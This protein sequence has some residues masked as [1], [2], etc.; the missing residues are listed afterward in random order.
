MPRCSVLWG[1]APF[2]KVSPPH[3]PLRCF[4]RVQQGFCSS[5]GML[6]A[7]P[8]GI[9]PLPHVSALRLCRCWLAALAA[10]LV[11]FGTSG[12]HAPDR[13]W[14]IEK[15]RPKRC[16]FICCADETGGENIFFCTV[17][18]CVILFGRLLH[19]GMN[20]TYCHM[21][22]QYRVCAKCHL[23]GAMTAKQLLRLTAK[24][25]AEGSSAGGAVMK[26]KK[27]QGI[28]SEGQVTTRNFCRLFNQ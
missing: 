27:S 23:R 21:N 9:M 5:A 12:A 13:L 18:C 8:P 25:S 7:V 20:C 11:V 28:L 16:T 3:A 2:A 24:R 19:A 22:R 10:V 26:A 15:T 14:Q 17:S 6:E 4:G 1:R